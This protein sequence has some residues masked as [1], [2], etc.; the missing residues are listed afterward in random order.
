MWVFDDVI[1]EYFVLCCQGF[2]EWE[3]RSGMN[4]IFMSY[5][6]SNGKLVMP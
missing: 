3:F 2:A 5:A 6:W 1:W 4:S